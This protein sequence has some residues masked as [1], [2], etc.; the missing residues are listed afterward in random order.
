MLKI[1]VI[2][3]GSNAKAVQAIRYQNNKRIVVKHFGSGHTDLQL[4]E[5]L[6]IANQWV[7]DYSLQLSLFD[8]KNPNTVLNINHCAFLGVYFSF[9]HQVI[10][11]LQLQIG[12][13][14]LNQFLNDLVIVRILE[15]ASKLRSIELLD[16]YFG[17]KHR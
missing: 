12:F 9:F 13:G 4:D 8:D 17:I 15:P 14:S 2:T 3:T 10:R 7:V 16:T 1:R 5:L 11:S 6:E